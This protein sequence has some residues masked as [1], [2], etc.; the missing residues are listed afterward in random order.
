MKRVWKFAPVAALALAGAVGCNDFL[1]GGELSEDPNRPQ[2]ATNRQLFVGIQSAMS[3]LLA[4]D[5]ARITQLYS[6][7]FSGEIGQYKDEYEYGITEST[8]NGFNT[9]LYTGGGLVDIRKLQANTLAAGDSLFL[10]IAQIQEALLIGTAADLFGDIVYSEALQGIANPKLDEQLSVYD[11]VQTLLDQ[12]I[13]NLSRTGPTNVGPG[14]ADLAYAGSRT[15]YTRLA[16]TLKARYY[17]HTAE[18]RADAYGKALIEARLGLQ[19]SADDYV[20]V[21]S[22]SSGEQNFYYQFTQVEREGYFVPNEFFVN[23][24]ESRNDPRRDE[25]F[26]EDGTD[27]SEERAAPDFSQP[28]V[29]AAENLLIQAEA[30][31]RTGAIGEAVT[32]LTAARA[33]AGLGASSATSGTALLQEILTEKYIA[34]FQSFEAFNDY[35]RTCFPNLTPTVTGRKIPARF[36]YDTNERQTNTNIANLTQ[37]TRNDNDPANTTVLDGSGAACLGQ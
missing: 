14:A 30:A 26:D 9:G 29:T 21:F 13:V 3:A 19:S 12:A 36:F 34:T 23:L 4:S 24:L 27:L 15:K 25:Y 6:Q 11:A 28:L 8:T 22:G 16:H 35:K 37:P 7:Q 20:A 32:A 17:L 33:L 31:Y 1:R 18:V 2:T 10:G 5:L